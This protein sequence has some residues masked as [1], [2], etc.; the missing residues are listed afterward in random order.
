M[1]RYL[2]IILI[3]TSIIG[4]VVQPTAQSKAVRVVDDQSDY[5]CSFVSVVTGSGS[6]GWTTA[7]DAEGAMAEVRNR[8]ASAGANAIRVINV[9][10]NMETTVVVAEALD[11]K[12]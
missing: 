2:G 9:D 4:C 6:L 3:T 12:F 8:A 5:S 11:C 7:H 10:S 1:H